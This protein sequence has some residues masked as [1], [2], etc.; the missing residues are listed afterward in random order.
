MPSKSSIS[1]ES[2]KAGPPPFD[3]TKHPACSRLGFIAHSHVDV[4]VP[5]QLLLRAG[6]ASA[7]HTHSLP[8]PRLRLPFATRADLVAHT[9]PSVTSPRGGSDD[10]TYS[11]AAAASPRKHYSATVPK[12][13]CGVVG[14]VRM[15]VACHTHCNTYCKVSERPIQKFCCGTRP[16]ECRFPVSRDVTVIKILIY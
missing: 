4:G 15:A 2:M 10:P 9:T 13:H 14:I 11:L 8:L 6:L 16:S 7:C 5:A 12:H 1:F 3:F